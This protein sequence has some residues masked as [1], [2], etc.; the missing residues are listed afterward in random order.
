LLA[1][2]GLAMEP[3]KARKASAAAERRCGR[4][5]VAVYLV[6]GAALLL[7]V[8]LQV[9]L[10]QRLEDAL[11]LLRY[12]RNLV[13]GHGFVFNP[14]ERVLGVTTPLYALVSAALVWLAGEGAP[15]AQNVLGVAALLF[16]GLFAALLARR[17]AGGGPVGTAAGAL[18]GTLCLGSFSLSYLY[19]GMEVHLFA[20]L[21]LLAYWLFLEHRELACGVALGVAFLTRYD[22]ALLALVLGVGF[23]VA[24]RRPP[25]RMVAAFFALA[26][27]WLVFAQLYFGSVLPATLAAKGGYVGVVDYLYRVMVDWKRTFEAVVAA[28]GAPRGV[29]DAL[30]WVLPL[31]VPAGAV[32]AVL[33]DRRAVALAAHP[34]LHV[35][36]YALIGADPGF[37]WHVY[38]VHPATWIFASVAVGGGVAMLA[39]GRGATTEV[40]IGAGRRAGRLR[41]IAVTVALALLLVPLVLHLVDAGGRRYRVDPLTRDLQAIAAWLDPRYGSETSLLHPAIGVLGWETDLRIVDQAGLVT[42]G[43]YYWDGLR[44]TSIAVVVGEH[45]PDLV[46]ALEGHHGELAHLGY[47]IVRTFEGNA[48]YVLWERRGGR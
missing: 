21:V 14:G 18:A 44:H 7:P 29:Q 40:G 42:P 31:L 22:A 2:V 10:P 41:R 13:E 25:W 43:L 11:I 35:L 24:R 27:P 4:W 5:F 15:A 48:R 3:L 33:R 23:L 20:A 37:A 32:V 17:L 46:L 19:F 30:A 47:A 6:V 39:R 1:T 8:V 12:G 28:Y 9:A 38:L 45:R 36:A 16:E 26:L 34:A